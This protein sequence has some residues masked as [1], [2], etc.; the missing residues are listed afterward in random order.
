VK[1]KQTNANILCLVRH[2]PVPPE[3][4]SSV[5]DSVLEQRRPDCTIT[6]QYTGK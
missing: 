2:G 3:H 1:S 5:T 6:I 4:I